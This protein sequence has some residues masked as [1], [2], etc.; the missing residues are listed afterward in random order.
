MAAA[1]I[2]QRSRT[3]KETS[4]ESQGKR[5]Q[6]DAA[7]EMPWMNESKV[8]GCCLPFRFV[9]PSWSCPSPRC[10]ACCCWALLD[11]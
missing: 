9:S 3:N 2:C 7:R 6:N 11:V 10:A 8:S 1:T 5:S 4:A